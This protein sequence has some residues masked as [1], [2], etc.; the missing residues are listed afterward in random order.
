VVLWFVGT[1]VLAVQWV[2]RDPRFDYRVLVLGVLLPDLVDGLFGGARVL[3][4]LLGSVV[5]LAGVMLC[6]IGRR[7]TRR[8][9][10]ALPIGTFLHLV[11]DGAFRRTEV[12]WW[13][14]SGWGFDGARLPVVERGWW[15]LLLEAVGL[16]LCVIIWR[17]AGLRDPERRTALWR[18]GELTTVV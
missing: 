9:W 6:T 3:H 10:L 8:R 18:R 16:V 2:L 7:E 14:A 5:L 12:F 11:L 4:T 1:S 13:P 17:R 15:N